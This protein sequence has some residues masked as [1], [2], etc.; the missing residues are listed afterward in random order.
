MFYLRPAQS[1]LS[2]L[3]VDELVEELLPHVDEPGYG[4]V[5]AKEWCVSTSA[6]RGWF[7]RRGLSLGRL[8]ESKGGTARRLGHEAWA[9]ERQRRREREEA[10]KGRCGI[11][12]KPCSESRSC[13]Y[14]GE[15]LAHS[16]GRPKDRFLPLDMC[17]FGLAKGY[18]KCELC[19]ERER[20]EE[21]W[22]CWKKKDDVRNVREAFVVG[23]QRDRD[24]RERLRLSSFLS[25][26]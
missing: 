24:A 17:A 1:A 13:M 26:I 6:I 10:L 11:T 21:T 7:D 8:L 15:M 20:C 3:R 16:T 4:L 25:R 2:K 19:S 12:K 14:G 18:E 22:T 23:P 9:S 5:K